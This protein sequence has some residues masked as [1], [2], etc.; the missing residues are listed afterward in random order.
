MTGNIVTINFSFCSR[1]C[2]LPP[3]DFLTN[4]RLRNFEHFF[5][6][7]LGILIQQRIVHMYI[8]TFVHCILHYASNVAYIQYIQT[9]KYME[10]LRDYS[11]F[12]QLL[13]CIV[14]FL[15]LVV[16]EHRKSEFVKIRKTQAIVKEFNSLLLEEGKQF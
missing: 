4:K 9:Y 3:C 8:S 6:L 16:V 13:V 1:S 7:S 10:I 15:F 11:R 14:E 5:F 12:V 2:R